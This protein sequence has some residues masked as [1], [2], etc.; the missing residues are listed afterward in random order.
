MPKRRLTNFTRLPMKERRR[1]KRKEE[2]DN[3]KAHGRH[4]RVPRQKV[5][6]EHLRACGRPFSKQK[7]LEIGT[8]GKL[9]LVFARPPVL[10]NGREVAYARNCLLMS[11]PEMPALGEMPNQVAS[12]IVGGSDIYLSAP[13]PGGD[14]SERATY[15]LYIAIIPLDDFLFAVTHS[16]P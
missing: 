16:Q 10:A 14:Q 4:H 11:T 6:T 15:I 5:S 13:S 2:S 7:F 8:L 9:N 12:G 1:R 3:R